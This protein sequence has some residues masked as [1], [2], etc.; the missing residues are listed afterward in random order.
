MSSDCARI[1]RSSLTMDI[2]FEM[3]GILARFRRNDWNGRAELAVGDETYPL[4]S[5]WNLRTH[6]SL[7]TRRSWN[8]RVGD[9]QVEIVKDRKRWFAGF[10]PAVFS[11]LVDGNLVTQQEGWSHSP[12]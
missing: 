7:S 2:N 1:D 5:P 9:H 6:F 8:R 12:K 3:D 4:Q 11:V 10:R